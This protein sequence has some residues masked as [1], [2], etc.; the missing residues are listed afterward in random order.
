MFKKR[1][2]PF[3]L[4]YDIFCYIFNSLLINFVISLF[5]ELYY[6]Q[7]CQRNRLVYKFQNLRLAQTCSRHIKK[8]PLFV[9]FLF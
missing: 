6:K 9:K 3:K 7:G 4:T 5:Y 8:T 2:C 1:N